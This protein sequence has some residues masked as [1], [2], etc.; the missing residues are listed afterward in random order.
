M[1]THR[2][3][4]GERREVFYSGRVQGV[5]FRYTVRQL[6]GSFEAAGYVRNLPDGRVQLVAEGT[7]AELDRF[8]A[9]I[10]E[11]MSGFIRDAAVDVR[12]ST[13]EFQEFEIRH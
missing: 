11:R 1:A 7:P 5:G 9:A 8:L 6:A 4:L 12:P 3:P 13:G 10:A 2:Q